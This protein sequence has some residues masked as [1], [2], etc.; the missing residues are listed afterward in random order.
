MGELEPGS[1]F[2]GHRIDAVA[3][4][5]RFFFSGYPQQQEAATAT[6]DPVPSGEALLIKGASSD[7]LSAVD[8]NRMKV[9]WERPIGKASRVIGAGD[10][11]G[12]QGGAD[13]GFVA[14]H[15]GGVD[16]AVA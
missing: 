2:A 12:G 8:P 4:Q 7:R 16:V 3:G 13:L 6:S 9:L 14:V 5:S 11:A 15:L 1:V 10:G